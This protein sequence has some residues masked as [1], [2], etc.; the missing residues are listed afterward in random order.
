MR[1]QVL[2]LPGPAEIEGGLWY[3]TSAS[4]RFGCHLHEELELNAVVAGE[5]HY[6]FPHREVRVVGPSLLFIPPRV[7]H[8][9]L[10]SSA[11]LSM[12]VYSFRMSCVAQVL[13]HTPELAEPIVAGIAPASLARL[14]ALSEQGL[15][16]P[17]LEDF[18]R[19]LRNALE[20]A[21][22]SWRHPTGWTGRPRHPAAR[23]AARL[24]SAADC[25]ST[26]EEL[27]HYCHLSRTRLSRLF[28]QAY[29]VSMVHYR[30]H[31]RVQRFIHQY[32]DGLQDNMLRSALD[33]GFG[34]YAQFYRAFKQVT[35][36]G[37][38]TH[39]VRVRDGIVDPRR[40]GCR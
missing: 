28:S 7:E 2:E 35:G 16:R 29:G 40:T 3:S 38:T 17:A 18:N 1:S 21:A 13:G 4:T 14:C 9:L 32:G 37:P 39:L 34:S 5:V 26:T 12:W 27:A 31:H 33:V 8:E 22:A 24:L 11:D 36:Y 25:P 23:R 19:V 30:S 10:S 15:L 20:L 6:R